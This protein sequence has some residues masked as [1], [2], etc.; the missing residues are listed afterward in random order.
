MCIQ[1]LVFDMGNVLILFS[2]MHYIKKF[3]LSESDEMILLNHVFR[4]VE[5]LCLDHGTIDE[6]EAISLCC[7]RLPSHLHQ[8]ARSIIERWCDDIPAIEGMEELVKEAKQA[9]YSLYL[10]S[11]TSKRF[12]QFRQ[13]INALQYFDGVFISAD[14]KLLKPD[15]E[16][17]RAFCQ[18]FE[19]DPGTCLFI[20]DMP[21]NIYGAKMAGMNGIVFHGDALSLKESLKS[22]G[23]NI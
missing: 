21:S 3:S 15:P 16:I 4:S 20:D 23:I 22:S 17:Y 5:W 11:N 10:L 9:G 7:Q 14:W 19:L 13:H 18:H 6:E 1:H 12:H 2:P 8:P